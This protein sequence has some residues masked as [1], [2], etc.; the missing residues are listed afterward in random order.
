ML[1]NYREKILK[2]I[3]NSQSLINLKFTNTFKEKLFKI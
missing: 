2:K 1:E 3:K